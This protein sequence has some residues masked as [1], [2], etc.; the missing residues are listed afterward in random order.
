MLVDILKKIGQIYL[1]FDST[2]ENNELLQRYGN[3]FNVLI[4]NI[5]KIDDD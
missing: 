2:D 1:T 5:E 4:D 3:V